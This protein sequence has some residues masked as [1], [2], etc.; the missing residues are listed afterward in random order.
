[1][2]QKIDTKKLTEELA[3]VNVSGVRQPWHDSVASGLTPERL[4][5]IIAAVDQNDILEYLTLAEEM[6]ERDLH[7]HSVLSTRKNA[8]SG[9]EV[10]VEAYSDNAKDVEIADY[11]RG[12]IK[13]DNFVDL[14]SDLTDALGKSFSVCEIMWD[15]SGSQ[16]APR[17]FK[18]RDQR[19]FQFDLNTGQELRLRDE[20]DMVNGVAL[21]PYKFIQHRPRIKTGLPIRGGLARLA[22]VAYMCKSYG[23][24][25]WMAFA[26]VFGMPLRVGKYD[27]S[28]TAQQKADLLRAVASIGTDA[29][30]IIPET[31][32]IDFVEASKAAG[33]ETLF[34]GMADW[35][36]SQVSKGVL[37][38]TMT[39]DNGSS[40]SQ[41]QVHNEVRKDLLRDDA[42]KLAAT[43]R[44]D[45]IRPIVDLNF[46]SLPPAEYPTFRLVIDEP[47]DLKS[48]AESL[49]PLIDRGLK[50][51][52]SIILD[53]F[54]I[55]EAEAGSEVLIPMAV[56]A[57]QAAPAQLRAAPPMSTLQEMSSAVPSLDTATAARQL[58]S[59]DAIDEL[60]QQEL[61]DWR[62]IMDPVLQ[63]ILDHAKASGNYQD[64]LSGLK[65]VMIQ[66]DTTA[67]VERLATA[68]FK[69]RG[70]GDA[71]DEDGST[72]HA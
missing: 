8:A 69:A 25:D 33:G 59:P 35:W 64:F 43:I 28:A 38:Q 34:R 65:G 21:D 32:M 56:A 1:M 55:P 18:H 11:V 30:C 9:L 47:E 48:L 62:R 63:P 70:V 24:K 17:E 44:R 27:V 53:K 72:S 60:M 52:A 51:Q 37:G 12:V 20:T 4:A 3:T 15:R 2:A 26:E 14:L 10:V 71:T 6:E 31:M 68:T 16:W 58:E 54:G 19:H 61:G 45:L 41:A 29:A 40:L 36:D 13:G 39:A 50:V 66:M 42:R 46:G 67:F 57:A 5:S 7:Y 23:I 49:S 22:C